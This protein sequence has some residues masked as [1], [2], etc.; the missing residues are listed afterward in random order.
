MSSYGFVFRFVCLYI[1]APCFF[2]LHILRRTKTWGFVGTE[3]HN[4]YTHNNSH[5]GSV[6]IRS[7]RGVL[8]GSLN[9][10]YYYSFT[11]YYSWYVNTVNPHCCPPEQ[12]KDISSY[13]IIIAR[14]IL[15]N[16]VAHKIFFF[17]QITQP[18]STRRVR[19]TVE[20]WMDPV[21]SKTTYCIFSVLGEGSAGWGAIKGELLERSLYVHH[22]PWVL[23]VPRPRSIWPDQGLFELKQHQVI[24][25]QQQHGYL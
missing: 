20:G 14:K 5:T 3:T 6:E 19:N 10:N 21:S 25:Q 17:S 11:D 1:S 18:V 22:Q 15:K 9:S 12:V 7:H 16:I 4:L 2:F 23:E 8:V 24:K 13:K